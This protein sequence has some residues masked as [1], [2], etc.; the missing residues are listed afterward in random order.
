MTDRIDELI[1]IVYEMR[2]K[3]E[4]LESEVQNVKKIVYAILSGIITLFFT[5][6]A[7]LMGG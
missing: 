4:K 6:I 5:L 7:K 1:Q 3:I 2:G